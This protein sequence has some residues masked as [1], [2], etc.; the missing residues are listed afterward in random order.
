MT[1]AQATT[2]AT[3]ANDARPMGAIVEFVVLDTYPPNNWDKTNAYMVIMIPSAY[4]TEY[5]AA[6]LEQRIAFARVSV[7]AQQTVPETDED[8]KNAFDVAGAADSVLQP[9]LFP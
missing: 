8:Y 5:G 2:N 4:T 7:I 1:E 9:Y 6:N 3:Q